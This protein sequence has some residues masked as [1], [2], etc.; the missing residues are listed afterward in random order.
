MCTGCPKKRG[1]SLG[2][3]EPQIKSLKLMK[4]SCDILHIKK[5]MAK[6]LML[7]RLMLNLIKGAKIWRSKID[8]NFQLFWPKITDYWTTSWEWASF[9]WG[10][11][12][13]KLLQDCVAFSCP[14]T[15]RRSLCRLWSINIKMSW[16]AEKNEKY[17]FCQ[18]QGRH[19]SVSHMSNVYGFLSSH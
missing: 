17:Q 18:W 14:R 3:K 2:E 4:L 12:S 19:Q 6:T 7:D 15:R 5:L 8:C 9:N 11:E 13:S 16:N 10:E 1:I